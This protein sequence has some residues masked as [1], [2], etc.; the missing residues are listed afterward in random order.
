MKNNSD[1][2]KTVDEAKSEATLAAPSGSALGTRGICR[3]QSDKSIGW[4]VRRIAKVSG[5]SV[6]LN[7]GVSFSSPCFSGARVGDIWAVCHES[8]GFCFGRVRRAILLEPV[9]EV[10]NA[11]LSGAADSAT[12]KTKETL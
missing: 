12:P 7:D 2:S 8:G 1:K 4:A 6:E 9:R 10:P 11:E 3:E 5:D